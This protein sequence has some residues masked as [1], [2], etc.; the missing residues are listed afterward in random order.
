M[1]LFNL[2]I[3][4]IRIIDELHLP[5]FS[6]SKTYKLENILPELGIMDVFNTQ[7]DLSGI[8]GAKDVRVSQVRNE[9][10][11]LSLWILNV[12]SEDHVGV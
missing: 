4:I 8:A 9:T 7:A 1:W 5:K 12:D 3:F 6:L 11:D 2:N 10:E